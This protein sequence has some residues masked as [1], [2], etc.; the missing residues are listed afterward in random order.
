MGDVFSGETEIDTQVCVSGV[1]D[2][3][4]YER[5]KRDSV[6]KYMKNGWGSTK[7]LANYAKSGDAQFRAY[8]NFGKHQF[9]DGLPRCE[10]FAYAMDRSRVNNFIY[11]QLGNSIIITGFQF[12][13]NPMDEDWVQF[14]LQEDYDYD[15]DHSTLTRNDRYYS[16]ISYAYN[17]T[18]NKY[19]A[20]LKGITQK[21]RVVSE[22]INHYFESYDSSY[23][24]Q[25]VVTSH[26][27]TEILVGS[28]LTISDTVVEQ[29][30]TQ[31]QVPVGT[32]ISSVNYIPLSTDTVST[33]TPDE[34][35]TVS[36]D[37]YPPNHLFLIVTYLENDTRKIWLC[38]TTDYPTFLQYDTIY[39]SSD[40]DKRLE[41][42][43]IA[44]LRFW[45]NNIDSDRNTEKYKSTKKLLKK[46]NL[47]ID[48]VI[49]QL[50]EGTDL[51]HIRHVF[52]GYYLNP[53]DTDPI[54][55]QVLWEQFDYLHKTVLANVEVLRKVTFKVTE[56]TNGG[57]YN[58]E[59]MWRHWPAE[60]KEEVIG[61]IGTYKHY[62]RQTSY[63]KFY[64][65]TRDI[66][67]IDGY[68]NSGGF[69]Y[70]GMFGR[71]RIT[72]KVSIVVYDGCELVSYQQ[73]GEG[74][75]WDYYPVY[76][77]QVY[78]Q[79]IVAPYTYE[80]MDKG[81]Y[82]YGHRDDGTDI[83][84][85]VA[86]YPPTE[87]GHPQIIEFHGPASMG[88]HA[89]GGFENFIPPYVQR[90]EDY[91]YRIDGTDLPSTYGYYPDSEL[92]MQKQVDATHTIT[93]RC[94]RNLNDYVISAEDGVDGGSA[95]HL[96]DYDHENQYTFPL[97]VGTVNSLGTIQK[98]KLLGYVV[99]MTFFSY[100]KT[101]LSWFESTG[102]FV[103]SRLFM[104]VIAAVSFG[105]AMTV[106]GPAMAGMT[107]TQAL[108]AIA[109]KAAI[110]GALYLALQVISSLDIGV[111]LK[112]IASVAVT[113]VSMYAGGMF[114]DFNM[115]TVAG[116]LELPATAM[117]V[118]TKD[119][120]K[121]MEK[122]Q[123]KQEEFTSAYEQRMEGFDSI[124]QKFDSGLSTG[125]TVE[126][127]IGSSSAYT[128]QNLATTFSPSLFYNIGT[129]AYLDLDLVL[130]GTYRSVSDYCNNALRLG[131]LT[132]VSSSEE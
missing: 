125:S 122:L 93:Y 13:R 16:Y 55:S 22:V 73:D 42:Y 8:Y 20:T 2:D 74:G 19:D 81:K 72:E 91:D 33:G 90:F 37:N 82:V 113:V 107:A 30:H 50:N 54:I 103:V 84:G 96:T 114:N 111:E 79:E 49:Q 7:Y 112:I 67:A 65:I 60:Q 11:S 110:A 101:E 43:P 24:T 26:R 23:D 106:T 123:G 21:K 89:F 31:E 17:A 68:N 75:G 119:M 126:L 32:G 59:Y 95:I 76:G 5:V 6:T 46:I 48:D 71:R 41:V 80:I 117:D 85:Y 29:S 18:T 57:T 63:M 94:Y 64:R 77:N 124:M 4:L 27:T 116:L 61:P 128:D 105:Y 9:I 127:A 98:T 108:T 131:I 38:D 36:V 70:A 120:S 45:N 97:F 47:N 39:S 53:H 14:K 56:D 1:K 12:Y 87:P 3:Q 100:V 102:F 121:K 86:E 62:I 104:I 99:H 83:D 118:Y 109:T 132:E 40:Y 115:S 10:V 88:L 35:I 34:N 52:F 69:A 130:S 66:V 78:E 15:Y 44:T 25:H 129:T 28:G 92:V 58:C 51:S